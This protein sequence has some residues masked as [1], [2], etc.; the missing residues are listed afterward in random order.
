M[1]VIALNAPRGQ[2][3][4]AF[5]P[6]LVSPP[7]LQNGVQLGRPNAL[8]LHQN[9][10]I[11]RVGVEERVLTLAEVEHLWKE[12]N[13]GKEMAK[14][15]WTDIRSTFKFG[16]LVNVRFPNRSIKVRIGKPTTF[17]GVIGKKRGSF[18][19]CSNAIRSAR[20]FFASASISLWARAACIWAAISAE[21]IGAGAKSTDCC[22]GG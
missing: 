7:P 12:G 4:L 17:S 1:P 13:W 14:F 21:S 11:V 20:T 6:D 10:R 2:C 9:H 15:I 18:H 8:V 5:G 16:H 22:C 3:E 19:G